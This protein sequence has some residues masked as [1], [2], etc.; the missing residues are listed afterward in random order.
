MIDFSN[1][2]KLPPDCV[3]R[4]WLRVICSTIIRCDWWCCLLSWNC[5]RTRPNSVF[6][7]SHRLY[8]SRL[9]LYD[10]WFRWRQRTFFGFDLLR[11]CLFPLRPHLINSHLLLQFFSSFSFLFFSLLRFFHLLSFLLL[12]CI[13]KLS[14]FICV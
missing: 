1:F 7:H 14:V 10:F 4:W 3:F 5:Q 13:Q 8:S 12:Q 6:A 9:S 11:L 2:R